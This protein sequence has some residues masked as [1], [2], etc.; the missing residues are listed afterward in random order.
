MIK[1]IVMWNVF[2]EDEN[3]RLVIAEL[4]KNKF[5]GLVGKIPGLLEIEVGIDESKVSYACDVVLYSVFQ[6]REALNAYST[7]PL[8][9]QIREELEG[10]RIERHQVDYP[11]A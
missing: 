11:I 2:G 3:S 6:S 5:E 1:H 8:H 7:H 4:V 10:L 9:L